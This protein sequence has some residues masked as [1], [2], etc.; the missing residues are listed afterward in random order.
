MSERTDPDHTTALVF[1]Q[2]TRLGHFSVDEIARTL[3]LPVETV[4]KVR[5]ELVDLNLLQ[6]PAH[7]PELLIPVHPEVAVTELTSPAER[8][9]SR[10]QQRISDIRLRLGRLTPAYSEGRRLL[11]RAHQGFHPI[12][13]NGQIKWILK[14]QITQCRSEILIS[15]QSEPVPEDILDTVREKIRDAARHGIR[16]RALCRHSALVDPASHSGTAELAALGVTVRSRP[17]LVGQLVIFDREHAVLLDPGCARAA[18]GGEA[19]GQE[20]GPPAV[21]VSEPTTVGVLCATFDQLWQDA[22]P[23]GANHSG[24]TT[25]SGDLKVAIVRLLAQGHKDEVVA[26]RLGLSVRQCRRY[27]KE[28]MDELEADSRFQAGAKVALGG[29]LTL[30]QTR[31]DVA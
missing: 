21:T 18:G 7:N 8:D 4:R 19:P 27:V 17:E 14:E 28:I 11:H 31:S 1:G 5:R 6:S 29:A 2:A 22:T 30:D 26:R 25:I 15:G 9:I 12:E 23:F 24:C 10:L 16:I 20:A 3:E 13:T